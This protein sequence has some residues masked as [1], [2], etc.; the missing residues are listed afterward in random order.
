MIGISILKSLTMGDFINVRRDSMLA[1]L[2]I[3]PIITALFA[4]LAVPPLLIWLLETYGLDLRVYANDF[5]GYFLVVITPTMFGTI[6]GFLLLDERDDDTLTALQVTPLPLNGYLVYR[7]GLPVLISLLA[8][9]LVFPLAGIR[10]PS[11]FVL[12]FI[13]LLA[14]LEA[15]LYTLFLAAFS[16]NKVAGLALMKGMSAVT[17]LPVVAVFMPAGWQ[18]V[19]GLIPTYWP[20]KMFWGAANGEPVWAYFLVGLLVHLIYL[21]LLLKRFNQ[22]MYR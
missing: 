15:P 10:P 14:A 6:I 21:V 7:L 22:V 1:L 9:I 2:S 17:L 13:A 5:L 8:A 4:R 12:A 18:L 11:W 3:V 16:E 20:L 19:A